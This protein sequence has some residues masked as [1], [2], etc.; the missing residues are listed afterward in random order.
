MKQFL[1]K[2]WRWIRTPV[3]IVI[4]A[5]TLMIVANAFILMYAAKEFLIGFYEESIE[6][7]TADAEMIADYY[8]ESIN[9]GALYGGKTLEE[10][11]EE[12]R[13]GVLVPDN[14]PTGYLDFV[15]EWDGNRIK[16]ALNFLELDS[17][18]DIVYNPNPKHSF[19]LEWGHVDR[20]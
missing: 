4:V 13:E 12:L 2:C 6:Y 7:T 5:V 20:D 16:N 10:K 9:R 8:Q 11:V 15:L 17:N 1:I 3:G 19:N 18:G 14:N